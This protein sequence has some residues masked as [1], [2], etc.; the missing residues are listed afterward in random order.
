MR[1]HY[2]NID[3]PALTYTIKNTREANGSVL[4]T[5]TTKVND[6]HRVKAALSQSVQEPQVVGNCINL[7]G[8]V[9]ELGA[10]AVRWRQLQ[11]VGLD[12]RSYRKRMVALRVELESAFDK[13]LLLQRELPEGS[14]E[15]IISEDESRLQEDLRAL[16]LHEFSQYHSSSSKLH[17]FQNAAYMLDFAKN[18]TGAI[19]GI[20]SI[21]GS[22]LNRAR[23][24]GGA[25]IF[26]TIS[27]T[28][29]LMIPFAGRVAGN[30][31]STVDRH[32]VSKDFGKVIAEHNRDITKDQAKL[33]QSMKQLAPDAPETNGISLR[34]FGYEEIAH[35]MRDHEENLKR[36]IERGR[37]VTIENFIYGSII[38]STK[39]SLGICGILAGYRYYTQPWLA[40]RLQA[41]GNTSYT[42]GTAF[43]IIENTRVVT[44]QHLS[45]NRLR[46]QQL[47]PSQLY[48]QRLGRLDVVDDKLKSASTSSPAPAM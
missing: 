26:T 15:A 48:T 27:G 38:G 21:E 36:L 44:M 13:R 19:G 42:A 25:A 34:A 41:A 12:S 39:V 2:A 43:S 6:L 4:T 24:S 18:S 33:T 8:D 11:H 7:C 10:N 22:H 28:M 32:V 30:W 9:F 45:N 20:I 5:Y 31:A 37:K 29:T 17:W 1:L 14:Q 40:S 23:W 47:L 3:N 35:N 46:E 16:L